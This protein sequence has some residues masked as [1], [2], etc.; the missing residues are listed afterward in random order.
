MVTDDDNNEQRAPT[1]EGKHTLTQDWEQNGKRKIDEVE[2][3]S[4]VEY[5][6]GRDIYFHIGNNKGEGKRKAMVMEHQV[7]RRGQV[8]AVVN[9]TETAGNDHGDEYKIG[10]SGGKHGIRGEIKDEYAQAHTLVG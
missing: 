3:R 4:L 7:N 8:Q 6:V 5:M 9:G 10:V 2:D 1:Q